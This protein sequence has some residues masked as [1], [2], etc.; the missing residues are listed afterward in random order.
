M[1]AAMPRMMTAASEQTRKLV[2]TIRRAVRGRRQ[3]AVI[4][5]Q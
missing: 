2:P 5:Q 4:S 3:K 1:Q